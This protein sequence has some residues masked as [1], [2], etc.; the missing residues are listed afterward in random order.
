M[1]TNRSPSTDDRTP[2]MQ[3]QR[4][5]RVYHQQMY[6]YRSLLHDT[7]AAVRTKPTQSKFHVHGLAG[8]LTRPLERKE[9][10]GRVFA[11]HAG[12]PCAGDRSLIRAFQ[13]EGLL[14]FSDVIQVAPFSPTAGRHQAQRAARARCP[15]MRQVAPPTAST[16]RPPRSHQ[17]LFK[18]TTL[19]PWF[20]RACG[21]SKLDR[22]WCGAF[23]SSDT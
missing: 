22:S 1:G 6:T 16:A 3:S 10:R 23:D 18:L 9:I 12:T 20:A 13:D 5:P 19:R 17:R 4:T 2:T 11:E 14:F 8:L 7:L 15:G 21:V